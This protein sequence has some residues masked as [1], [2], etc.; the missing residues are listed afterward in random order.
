MWTRPSTAST[1]NQTS[2]TGPNGLPTA[3][4]PLLWTE[5]TPMRITTAMGITRSPMPG[6]A[7][8]RP[9][10]ADSTEMAGVMI[11]SP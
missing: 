3:P 9:S 10:T 2:I 4:V 5:K 7:T 1:A 11:P 6:S 8:S